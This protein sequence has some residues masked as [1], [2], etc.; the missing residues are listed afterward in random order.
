M[1]ASAAVS[2]GDQFTAL[3]ETT[4]PDGAYVFAF[5][6]AAPGDKLPTFTEAVGDNSSIPRPRQPNYLV[7]ART[8]RIAAAIPML[9]DMELNMDSPHSSFRVAWTPDGRAA[10]A[11]FNGRYSC[12]TAMLIEPAAKTF[13]DVTEQLKA[14]LRRIMLE[15]NGETLTE[16]LSAI[17]FRDAVVRD[18]GLLILRASAA[19]LGGG[20]SGLAYEYA[21]KFQIKPADGKPLLEL[22]KSAVVLE[23]EIP[24][25]D[26]ETQMSESFGQL[27]TTLDQDHREAL[28][29]D[30]LQWL[31]KRGGLASDTDRSAATLERIKELRV[32][33]LGP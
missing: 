18:S 17:S 31:K 29:E 8:R 19:D 10:L 24:A 27:H 26:L 4:S 7:N 22:L 5:G 16:M 23:N 9:H 25:S 33:L 14:P 1:C 32:R 2:A 3:P 12:D 28:Q 15:R 13:S 30:Q 20:G 6:P 11:L 21:L